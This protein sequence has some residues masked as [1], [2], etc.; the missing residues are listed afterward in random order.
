[1][2]IGL[3]VGVSAALL[4]VAAVALPRSTSSGH[5]P[6]APRMVD[7]V[8]ESLMDA[9]PPAASGSTLSAPWPELSVMRRRPSDMRVFAPPA[10]DDPCNYVDGMTRYGYIDRPEPNPHQNFYFT[11]GAYREGMSFRGGGSW[12]VDFP[13]ADRQFL[14][15][16][17]RTLGWDI[18]PCEN[19]IDLADPNLR[20]FPFLYML[21]VGDM[22]LSPL[23]IENFRNYLLAGGFAHIDDFWDVDEWTNFERE[24]RTVLPEFDIVDIPLDHMIF[25]IIYPIDQVLQVPSIN[26]GQSGNPAYYGECRGDCPA[27]VKGI[28]NDEGRLMVVMTHN[29]DMGDAW[30]WAEQPTYPY[31]RS[32]YAFSFAFNII[33]YAMVY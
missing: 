31:D 9:A 20:R 5:A 8:A 30:E 18:F 32:N 22:A 13:K 29:S 27:T 17:E 1:M 14:Y 25:K 2:K 19:P 3:L 6:A 10:Q 12:A 11:R 4:T 7:P 28:F 15:V 21:E 24:I 16:M 33:A 23:E 26:N